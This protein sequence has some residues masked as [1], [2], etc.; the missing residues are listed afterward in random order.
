[1]IAEEGVLSLNNGLV[2]TILREV[3]CYAGQFGAY[4]MTK[5]LWGRYIEGVH[6][7]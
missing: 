5:R 2:A 6:D 7:S 3:P 1:M 4:T